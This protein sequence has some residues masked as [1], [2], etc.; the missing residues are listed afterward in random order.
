MIKLSKRVGIFAAIVSSVAILMNANNQA[1]SGDGRVLVGQGK[2]AHSVQ[3]RVPTKPDY[4]HRIL[5]HGAH[6]CVQDNQC[7]AGHRCCSGHCYAIVSCQ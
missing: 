1:N 6:Q 4:I 7:G 3:S 5:G 2:I